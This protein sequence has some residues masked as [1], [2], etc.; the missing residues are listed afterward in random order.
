MQIIKDE[1]KTAVFRKR[2]NRFVVECTIGKR[3]A[4]AYLPNPGRLW[5]LLVPGCRLYVRRN[6]PSVRMPY[7]VLAVEKEGKPI[8]LH[9][10]MTNDVAETLLKRKLIPGW[11]DAEIVRREAAFGESRFDFL[12]RRGRQEMV[13]EVKNCTLFRDRLAMFPDAVT[14]RGSRHLRGLYR[15]AGEGIQTGVLFVV[16]WPRAEYFMPEH[17]TDLEFAQNL[18]KVHDTVDIKAVSVRWNG[19]LSLDGT[20][21][22]LI[23]PWEKIAKEAKDSGSYIV[24]LYLDRDARIEIGELGTIPFRKG[25]YL[26]TGSAKRGLTKRIERHQR[27]RKNLFWHIDYLRG[28]TSFC[29]ALPV[30]TSED[31]ECAIA[32][33]LRKIADWSVKGFGS[34]DCRCESHLFGME[35]DPVQLPAFIRML[36]DYRMGRIERELTHAGTPR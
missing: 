29:K 13:L 17:H 14:R 4:S 5:E 19:D 24:I 35:N 33:D 3:P 34:S 23:I 1:L 11:E 8:L 2:P 32:A 16:Q 27:L 26:Y 30:R 15:L 9:T 7:T 6:S 31:L 12:L 28:K 10:H 22:E 21:R 20:V 25:Y 36:Y 18:L